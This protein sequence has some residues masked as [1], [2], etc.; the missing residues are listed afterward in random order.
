M[1]K[2]SHDY[3]FAMALLGDVILLYLGIRSDHS[4]GEWGGALI[5]AGAMNTMIFVGF[6]HIYLD[7]EYAYAF[8]FFDFKRSKPKKF[9]LSEMQI[10]PMG[11][12][13]GIMK[14]ESMDK[15]YDA[16]FIPNSNYKSSM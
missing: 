1:K 12:M 7:A 4:I 9:K 5:S 6:R 3:P 16:L 10:K 14:L 2:I 11:M 8:H 13:P 15:S